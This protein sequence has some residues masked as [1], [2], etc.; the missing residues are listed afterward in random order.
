MNCGDHFD[1]KAGSLLVTA[2]ELLVVLKADHMYVQE[3][4]DLDNYWNAGSHYHGASQLTWLM[5][6]CMQRA[7]YR[8]GV[9]YF[10][11][12]IEGN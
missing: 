1:N 4:R 10:V 8:A 5:L 6:Q 7:L 9:N 2:G 3:D 11:I 12:V